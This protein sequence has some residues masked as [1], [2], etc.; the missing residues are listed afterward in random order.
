MQWQRNVFSLDLK[1][2]SLGRPQVFWEIVREM[3]RI[4]TAKLK[5]ALTCLA[6]CLLD[7]SQ[8]T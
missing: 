3:W 7:L 2:Q 1:E 5:D 4:K 8:K 6:V